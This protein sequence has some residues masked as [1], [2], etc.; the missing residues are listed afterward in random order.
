M[1]VVILHLTSSI[2][3]GIGMVITI[4]IMD[5]GNTRALL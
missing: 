2:A 5:I 4:T 1:E 3:L